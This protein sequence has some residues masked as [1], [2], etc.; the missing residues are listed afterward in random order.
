MLCAH[1]TLVLQNVTVLLQISVSQYESR[2]VTRIAVLIHFRTTNVSAS[3]LQSSLVSSSSSAM[4]RCVLLPSRPPR[5]LA[6]ISST[7]I[8]PSSGPLVYTLPS[9]PPP[10]TGAYTI[11]SSATPE[12]IIASRLGL[13]T[14]PYTATAVQNTVLYGCGPYRNRTVL[15]KSKLMTVR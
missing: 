8:I 7:Y 14:V 13:T 4:L 15:T 6:L 1:S 3:S 10:P 12:S 5:P 9:C 11:P 2:S